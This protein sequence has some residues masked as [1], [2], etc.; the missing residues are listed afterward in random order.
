M[1]RKIIRHTWNTLSGA[2]V[3]LLSIW[4]SGPG[5]AETDSPVYRW[6]Y[7]A[8]FLLW[9]IGFILQFKARTK[10]IGV[11][12]TVIPIVVYLLIL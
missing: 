7:L 11:F 8:L 2:F 4:M 3:L 5:I 10:G 6:Y 12:I 9:A 1:I